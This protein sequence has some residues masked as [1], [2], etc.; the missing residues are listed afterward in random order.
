MDRSCPGKGVG[1][2]SRQW[3]RQEGTGDIQRMKVRV[4]VAQ[5]AGGRGAG[6][7]LGT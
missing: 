7:G 4:T 2:C 5:T 6:G 3:Y 1:G